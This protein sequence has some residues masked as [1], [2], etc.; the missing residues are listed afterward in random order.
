[1]ISG[2]NDNHI[3]Y[4]LAGELIPGASWVVAGT[5]HFLDKLY[6]FVHIFKISLSNYFVE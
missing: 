3:S 4:C 1:M 5:S 6:V 2:Q